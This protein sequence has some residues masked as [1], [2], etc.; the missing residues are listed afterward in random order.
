MWIRSASFLFPIPIFSGKNVVNIKIIRL[1]TKDRALLITVI[2]CLLVLLKL[3]ACFK[4][5]SYEFVLLER[6][7]YLCYSQIFIVR[8]RFY[9]LSYFFLFFPI[10]ILFVVIKQSDASVCSL[11]SIIITI[12]WLPIELLQFTIQYQWKI[13]ELSYDVRVGNNINDRN[14]CKAYI[15]INLVPI[16]QRTNLQNIIY[17]YLIFSDWSLHRIIPLSHFLLSLTPAIKKLNQIRQTHKY[18]NNISFFLL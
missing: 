12:K 5:I 3:T 18:R 6:K 17:I 9:R 13:S 15:D 2:F 7:R 4:L 10:F 11:S 16:F 14:I 1:V 8:Y